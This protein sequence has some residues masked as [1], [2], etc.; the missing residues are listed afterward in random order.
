MSKPRGW[1]RK[2]PP[3]LPCSALWSPVLV[4]I[5]QIQLEASWQSSRGCAV[6]RG[7]PPAQTLCDRQERRSDQPQRVDT[8]TGVL[9]T[10]WG[11]ECPLRNGAFFKI[12]FYRKEGVVKILTV[13]KSWRNGTHNICASIISES[14]RWVNYIGK[15]VTKIHCFKAII[16]AKKCILAKWD[17]AVY[18]I[19]NRKIKER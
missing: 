14:Q 7:Q 13:L 12:Y 15:I 4:S 3:A 19:G 18:L 1:K 11:K 6:P 9:F 16:Y 5:G 2:T 17:W 10:P 8:D